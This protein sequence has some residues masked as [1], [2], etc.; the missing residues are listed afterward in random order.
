MP[1]SRV[2]DYLCIIGDQ[3]DNIPGLYGVGPKTAAKWLMEYG[4]IER[5]IENAGRLTPRRFCSVVYEKKAMLVLNRELIKLEDNLEFE[6]IPRQK[7]DLPKLDQI[8]LELE[9]INSLK[10]AERRYA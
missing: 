2:L 8:L 9:M 6:I 10:E 1:P 3:S 5:L 7:V 4:D